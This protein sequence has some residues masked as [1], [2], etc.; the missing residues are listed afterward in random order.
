[1]K[2]VDSNAIDLW[3]EYFAADSFR[4]NALHASGLQWRVYCQEELSGD[5]LK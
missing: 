4:A 1:M 5:I 3:L 2:P